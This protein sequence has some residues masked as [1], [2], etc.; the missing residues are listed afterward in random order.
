MN[1]WQ[2]I[3]GIL[4]LISAACVL[5]GTYI[6]GKSDGEHQ[7]KV[8]SYINEEE[9]ENLPSIKAL[10]IEGNVL[11]A[12]LIVRNTGNRDASQVKLLYSEKSTPKYFGMNLISGLEEIPRGTEFKM[13][14][15]LFSGIEMAI[16]LPNSEEG[17]QSEA[18][19]EL[20]KLQN[21]EKVFIARFYLEYYYN[22]ERYESSE[23]MA[24][25]QGSQISHF[26]KL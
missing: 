8:R 22:D 19:E 6:Q 4:S 17:F 20:R 18:A 15:N 1:S 21:G 24:V 25:I 12:Q 13:P 16:R 11:N 26:S 3:G 14:M 5:Y 2:I 10:R 7:A 9:K 23:Y